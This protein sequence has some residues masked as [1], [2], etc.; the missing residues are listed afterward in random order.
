MSTSALCLLVQ[1]WVLHLIFF[2][3]GICILYLAMEILGAPLILDVLLAA[4][5]T[6]IFPFVANDGSVFRHRQLSLARC[7]S[8]YV[9]GAG[10]ATTWFAAAN[11][12]PR[13]GVHYVY[14][15]AVGGASPL[16]SST[17]ANLT[18]ICRK[19]NAFD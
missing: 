7:S 5:F 19:D 6:T 8:S 14:D 10:G 2:G 13:V 9:P 11:V 1:R 4:A 16:M 12:L 15:S 17:R 18:W 3:I